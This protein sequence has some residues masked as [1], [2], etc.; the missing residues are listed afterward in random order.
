MFQSLAFNMNDLG[1]GEKNGK[2]RLLKFFLVLFSLSENS[3]SFDSASL[4]FVINTY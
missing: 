4:L 1:G 3:F 2:R